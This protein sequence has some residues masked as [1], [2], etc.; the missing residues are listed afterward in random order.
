MCSDD[1]ECHTSI[2]GPRDKGLAAVPGR[3]MDFKFVLLAALDYAVAL[4]CPR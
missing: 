3:E 2:G 4:N 1:C